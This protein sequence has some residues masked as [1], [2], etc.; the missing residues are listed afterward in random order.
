MARQKDKAGA[1]GNRRSGVRVDERLYFDYMVEGL[2][3]DSGLIASIRSPMELHKFDIP[4]PG[5]YRLSAL[6][7]LPVDV[8]AGWG[9]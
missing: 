1:V 8:P 3:G 7:D 2:T 9:L 5:G 6:M 4:T